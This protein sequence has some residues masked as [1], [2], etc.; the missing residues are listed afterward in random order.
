M[1]LEP[2][3]ISRRLFSFYSLVIAGAGLMTSGS[4][5]PGVSAGIPF[6][7]PFPPA[8][9]PLTVGLQD[10]RGAKRQHIEAELDVSEGLQ[11]CLTV[12]NLLL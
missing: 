7:P 5:A 3:F 1:F 8:P 10:R 2:V 6:P 4:G 12:S 11:A 9:A